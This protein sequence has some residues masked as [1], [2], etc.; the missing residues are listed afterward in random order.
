M[1]GMTTLAIA[2]VIPAKA[3]DDQNKAALADFRAIA[4]VLQSPRCQNCHPA[5]DVPHI[6]DQGQ[7]HRMNVSRKSGESGLPC[8]TCHRTKNARFAHGP[9]GAPNWHM[10]PREHPMA[11]EG[12][13][14]HQLCE[15]LKDPAH[16][17]GK[18]LEDL[19]QH[20]AGDL[21]VR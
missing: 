5:G 2:L 16:N 10:P 18:K 8:T 1:L 14:P 13:T 17:G 15:Q 6:G 7:R 4:S 21:L 19:H 11:F 9:P 12:K 3:G 20:F